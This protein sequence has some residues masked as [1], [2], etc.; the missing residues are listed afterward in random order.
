MI[1]SRSQRWRDRRTKFVDND[2]VIDP[3]EFGVEVINCTKQAKPFIQQ[4]HYAGSLPPTRLSVG[5][6]RKTGVEPSQLVG[7]ASFTQPMNNAAIP[8]HTGLESYRQGC[9]LGRF[10]LLDDIAGNG[11][12]M[13][14]SRALRAL[15]REKPEIEAII[16]Y[17]DPMIR[18]GADGRL[19]K[20]G[21]VGRAYVCFG[22]SYRGR[23]T[24]RLETMLPDGQVF[25]DRDLS[26]IRAGETGH[27][28]ATD[29]LLRQGARSRLFGE[30]PAEWLRSLYAGGFLT[31]RRNPGNHLYAFPMTVRAK[32]AG[33]GLPNL[34]YPRVDHSIM[35]GDVTALPLLAA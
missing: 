31:K 23:A 2:T 7:V 22:M 34:A 15:R 10:V 6:F 20:H 5:L 17:A 12:T 27:R 18:R 33:R 14:L 25:N 1:T 29:E 35:H 32:L 4:H 26:K 16:S 3:R 8:K 30:E 11:E 21:H 13:F 24:S 19:Q 9:E 28:Y